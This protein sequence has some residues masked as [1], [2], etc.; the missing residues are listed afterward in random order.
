[1]ESLLEH[2]FPGVEALRA[3]WR[4]ATVHSSCG[5]GCGSF[6]FDIDSVDPGPGPGVEVVPV[7]IEVVDETGEPIGG[8]AV[9][10]RDGYLHDVDV[11]SFTDVPLSVP[12]PD[13]L[14]LAPVEPE[15]GDGVPMPLRRW[16]HIPASYCS[17]SRRASPTRATIAV[18]TATPSSQGSVNAMRTA[19][20][21]LGP[22]ATRS[23]P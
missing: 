12:P 1:M 4:S 22:E 17:A 15:L 23:N 16:V 21:P 18:L 9:L 13:R 2:N 3:Q 14:A 6:G 10:L 8:I 20:R 7:D 19:V 5:C 11:H